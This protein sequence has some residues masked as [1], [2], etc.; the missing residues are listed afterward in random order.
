MEPSLKHF[1]FQKWRYKIDEKNI[2][3]P[4]INFIIFNLTVIKMLNSDL[5]LKGILQKRKQLY[6]SNAF[7]M[8]LLSFQ[9]MQMFGIITM[10]IFDSQSIGY[11][12]PKEEFFNYVISH[13]S[14]FN[15]KDALVIGD[16]LNTDIKG[17]CQ[18]GMDT[19]WV[20]RIGQ[21][22]PAEIKSTYTISNLIE[23]TSIC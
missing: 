4:L 15:R 23:L 18:S 20:N 7:W 19:C 11:Q 12:K 9:I 10:V 5:W 6:Y 21:I 14:E 16:S 2:I 3:H 13:I 1:F 22:S 17:G 8:L